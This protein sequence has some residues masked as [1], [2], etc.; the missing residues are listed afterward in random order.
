MV[1]NDEVDDGVKCENRFLV[2][3]APLNSA[4]DSTHYLLSLSD[5]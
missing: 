4:S 1:E 5:K 3:P 2:P